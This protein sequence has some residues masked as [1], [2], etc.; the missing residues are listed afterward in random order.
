MQ[1]YSVEKPSLD[2]DFSILNPALIGIINAAA[3]AV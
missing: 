3:I 1:T 2:R